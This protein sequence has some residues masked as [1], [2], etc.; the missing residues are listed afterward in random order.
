MWGWQC[1]A[2]S[3]R[4]LFTPDKWSEWWGNLHLDSLTLANVLMAASPFLLPRLSKSARSLKWLRFANFAALILVWSFLLIGIADSGAK[5]LMVGCYVWASS[6]LL[7][8]L[9]ALKIR[10]QTLATKYV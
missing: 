2:E 10:H 1:A 5:D 9:S 6:F 8:S 4:G 7:L 3:A